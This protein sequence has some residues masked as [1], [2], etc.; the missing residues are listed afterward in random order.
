[1]KGAMVKFLTAK[2]KSFPQK[3]T[4]RCISNFGR[5]V[6]HN[7]AVSGEKTPNTSANDPCLTNTYGQTT[8]VFYLGKSL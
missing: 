7:L 3:H 5:G 2:P 8:S 4:C 6:H 1:V